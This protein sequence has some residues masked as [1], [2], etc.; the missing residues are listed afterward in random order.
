MINQEMFDKMSE[1]MQEQIYQESVLD[2]TERDLFIS[3]LYNSEWGFSDFAC[4]TALEHYDN[5]K[6]ES[7]IREELIDLYNPMPF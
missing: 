7:E 2:E 4:V 5:G 3:W 6:P 1:E